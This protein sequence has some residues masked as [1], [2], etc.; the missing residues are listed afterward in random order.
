MPSENDLLESYIIS[1]KKDYLLKR[2]KEEN[3]LLAGKIN[4]LGSHSLLGLVL[5]EANNDFCYASQESLD[6]FYEI[7]LIFTTLNRDEYTNI[8]KTILGFNMYGKP[9]RCFKCDSFD[10]VQKDCCN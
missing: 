8:P 6:Y 7:L 9:I 2:I 3:E 10:H 5:A 1:V 4:E